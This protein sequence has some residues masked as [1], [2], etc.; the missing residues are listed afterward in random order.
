MSALTDHAEVLALNFLFNTET[1]TRPTAWYVALHD[2]DPGDTGANEITTSEDAD[3]ARKSVTFGAA[4]GGQCLSASQV[5]WTVNS[6]SAGFTVTHASI[7]DAATSGNC[8]IA[9]ELAVH[10]TL[11]A[12]GV[13]TFEIGEI[14]ATAD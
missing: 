12:N 14:I 2:G 7:W 1:A 4:S 8:L 13:L 6:G 3:Y 11:A 9:G 5:S 10:R